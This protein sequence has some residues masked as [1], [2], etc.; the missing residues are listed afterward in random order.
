[1]ANHTTKDMTKRACIVVFAKAPVPGETK[2]R[3]IPAIGAEHAAMLHAALV[4]RALETAAAT[5]HDVEL[6]CAPDASHSFFLECVED[7]DCTLSAQGDGDLGVRMLAAMEDVLADFD[8]A[9]IVGADCPSVTPEHIQQAIA[10]LVEHDV[11]L[12]PAEDGGY[13][14]IAARR[15]N[16]SMFDG[17]KWGTEDVLTQQRTALNLAGLSFAELET[18]WDVD[19]PEDLVRLQTLKPPLAFFLPPC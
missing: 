12:I 16:G 4:E 6:R 8:F 9:V 7:F 19:R 1:M 2:T 18:L 15:V 14:L 3:L 13:V 11:A 17:I 10:A 5:G